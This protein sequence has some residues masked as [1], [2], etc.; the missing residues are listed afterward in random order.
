MNR[1]QVALV[2]IAAV[3]AFLYWLT[4]PD[5]DTDDWDRQ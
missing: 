2:A 1:Y 3:I 4:Y 5:P